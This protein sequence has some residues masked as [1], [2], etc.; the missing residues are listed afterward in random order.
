MTQYSRHHTY[1]IY[2]WYCNQ[3]S[4]SRSETMIRLNRGMGHSLQLRGGIN[5][6]N[7][8]IARNSAH[9]P[10]LP[11]NKTQEMKQQRNIAVPGNKA[12]TSCQVISVEIIRAEREQF[13][14]PNS[15]VAAS[16]TRQSRTPGISNLSKGNI[17]LGSLGVIFGH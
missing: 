11:K 10:I 12:R 13:H 4:Y 15:V 16:D 6:G 3:I 14:K 1:S 7:S 2:L 5:D 9:L 17:V 8:R